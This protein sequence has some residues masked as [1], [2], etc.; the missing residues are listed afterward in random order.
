[1]RVKHLQRIAIA[2]LVAI[3][4]LPLVELGVRLLD[5]YRLTSIALVGAGEALPIADSDRA[6]A[7][8]YAA[9]IPLA[10][11]IHREW[12]DES[13]APPARVPLSRDLE[14]AVEQIQGRNVSSDMFKRWNTR[15]LQERVCSGDPF[16]DP[17][18]GFAFS[19]EPED[20]SVHPPYRYLLSATTPYKLTTNRFGFR[21]HEISAE[22]APG[23]VRIAFLGASTTVGSH[24]QPFSYPEFIERWLNLWA[25]QE[26]PGVRFET[27]NAGREGIAS[28]DT[29][30]IVREEL[31]PLEPD[32]F[33]YHEGANQFTPTEMIAPGDPSLVRPQALGQAVDLPGS[34]WSALMRR[35][36]VVV[37]RFGPG[38][39]AE[40]R[41]P[42]HQIQWPA[43]I[44]AELP[45][46]DAADLPLHLPEIVHDL[47]DMGRAASSIDAELVVTSFIWMA[48]EGL[49]VDRADHGGYFDMINLKYW[50]VTYAEM[51][52]LA[53]FQNRVFRSYAA[54]RKLPFID[55][56]AQYPQDIRLFGDPIH[57]SPEGDRLRAWIVFQGLVPIIRE[58]LR[59]HRLPVADR[60]RYV[61][62][63]VP[64]R[65]TKTALECTDFSRQQAL[66]GALP[67][68][69]L[70]ASDGAT[71]SGAA[72]K[73]VVT[74]GGRYSY[75]AEIALSDEARASR[76]SVVRVKVT[77]MSGSVSIGVMSRDRSQ[78][79]VYRTLESGHGS[80]NLFLRVPKMAD[81][82]SLV[83]SNA[84]AQPG[85]P[86]VVDVEE[87]AVLVPK[88]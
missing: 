13:P 78:F 1:M 87:T 25:A 8:R 12:F 49:V 73:H 79:L 31:L 14:E 67:L 45:D 82:G 24:G 57:M 34:T 33:V 62:P 75:A 85:Q 30:A 41:K 86:S 43:A 2:C 17:F 37:R 20:G 42:A 11:G 54:S 35:V 15:L 83:I 88:P 28:P 22:K 69:K 23:V 74:S 19:F 48:K 26:A 38:S 77:V 84:L 72:I 27:I 61:P 39:G 64:D 68:D 60:T 66:D 50:P 29:A 56:S 70:V 5:G 55:V 9:E 16:F 21:G 6:L 59:A 3:C 58:K 53:D 63:P 36:N 71:V 76:A 44:S 81:A 46:A 51:R 7:R 32:L 10:D 4:M 65:L 52:R 47:D 40:P 80:I 18:P